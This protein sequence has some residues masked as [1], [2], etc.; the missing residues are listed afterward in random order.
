MSVMPSIILKGNGG[1]TFGK[2]EVVWV[3]IGR[4]GKLFGFN[5]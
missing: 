3:G 1:E 5:V 4:K 2:R